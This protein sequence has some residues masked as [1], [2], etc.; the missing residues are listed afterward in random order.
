MLRTQAPVRALTPG[1]QE[2]ALAL[3]ARDPAANV[4]VAGR[5][6][7]GCLWA[8]PGA[9][10]GYHVGGELRSLIWASANLVPAECDEEAAEA[11]AGKA[12]RWR[13]QCASLFG[14]AEQIAALWQRLAPTWGPARTVRAEQPLLSIRRLPPPWDGDP[15]PRIRLARM[16][17]V[18]CVLPASA[19]MFTDEIGYP[20]YIGS[21]AGYRAVV[22]GL[23]RMGRTYVWCEGGRVMFKADIGSIGVDTAQ[24]QGVWLTPALRGQGLAEPLMAA[25]TAAI[26]RD[27]APE[28]SLYVNDFNRPA[29]A[30]YA[31]LGYQ[32]VGTFSTVLL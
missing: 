30:T 23:I 24:V 6:L 16:D 19:A 18:D 4:F 11:F 25:V 1:D 22:A 2:E 31:A 27:V 10:L 15:D 12:R 5:I 26:L 29:R 8:M 21:S 3:C 17:E 7:E 14:P 13:R 28:A 32:R 9:L 20:P